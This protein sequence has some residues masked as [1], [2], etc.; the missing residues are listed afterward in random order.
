[1]VTLL[2]AGWLLSGHLVSQTPPLAV[3]AG[4]TAAAFLTLTLIA[5]LTPRTRA[6]ARAGAARPRAVA[7]LAFLG[8]FVYYSGT[9]LGVDRIGVSGVGLIV[10]LLPC[11]TFVI[12]VAAFREQSTV[13][14]AGGTLIAVSAAV[15]YALADGGAAGGGPGAG[16]TGTLAAGLLLALAGTFTY[17]LYG[18]VYRQRMADI[19]PL[20]ALPAITGAGA[21]M[22][23]PAALFL[24]PLDGVGPGDWA[25]IALLGAVLTAPVFLISHALILLRGPLFTSAVALVVPLLIRLGEWALGWDTAPGPLVLALLGLCLAGVWLTARARS[26]PPAEGGGGPAGP[27]RPL[28]AHPAD[29]AHSAEHADPAPRTRGTP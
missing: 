9:L 17:A 25:G 7:L 4:R 12:G 15:G 22:L 8:F 18:Y 5:A 28:P 23:A 24:T 6:A 16:G 29:P 10:C 21:A 19:P 2:A 20:A 26:A 3:A 13:R 11:L 1:M 27:A 14:K